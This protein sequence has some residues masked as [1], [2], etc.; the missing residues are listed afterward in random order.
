M[1]TRTKISLALL[2]F[3]SVAVCFAQYS[4]NR[5]DAELEAMIAHQGRA[6]PVVIAH[7][8]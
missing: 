2:A 7:A 5:A 6:T 8:K 3:V 4:L 1:F